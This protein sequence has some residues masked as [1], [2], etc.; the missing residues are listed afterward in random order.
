M[1]RQ[2]LEGLQPQGPTEEV[3]YQID[4][5]P[6]ATS[7]VGVTVWDVTIKEDVTAT[8]MPGAAS[9]TVNEG[10]IVLPALKALTVGHT[11]EVRPLY[12]DGNGSKLEPLVRVRCG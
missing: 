8:V 3:I 12:S 5:T 7:I 11:Y 9:A 4:V 2:V 1:S 6:A 10:V